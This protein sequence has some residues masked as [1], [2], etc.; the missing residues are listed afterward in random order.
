MLKNPYKLEYPLFYDSVYHKPE[1]FWQMVF[2]PKWVREIRAMSLIAEYTGL[3]QLVDEKVR[4]SLAVEKGFVIGVDE[5]AIQ[6][7]TRNWFR[8]YSPIF[9]HML[10]ELEQKLGLGNIVFVAERVGFLGKKDKL[11]LKKRRLMEDD[12]VKRFYQIYM[13]TSR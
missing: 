1:E 9:N 13:T 2:E 3:D 4:N 10:E 5:I 7:N 12:I 11:S 8:E 6:I